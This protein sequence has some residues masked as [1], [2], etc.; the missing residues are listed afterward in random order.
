MTRRYVK[1]SARVEFERSIAEIET[2][3]RQIAPPRKINPDLG[4]Y[5]LSAAILFLSAKL[6][7]YIS[8]LFKGIC[9]EACHHVKSASAVPPSLLGWAFLNDGHADRSKTFVARNDEGD[10]IRTTGTYLASELV[11][12]GNNYLTP[13][14]FRGID[15]KAYPSVKNLKRMFRRLGIEAIFSLLNKRMKCS[16]ENNLESFNAI[17]G[18]LAHSGISGTYSYNDIKEQIL[19]IQQLVSAIDKETFYYLRSCNADIAWK[20]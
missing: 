15:D 10:F 13:G 14:R 9:Q 19:K 7:N 4:N 11:Q 5:I 18:A 20:V 16:A 8:D 1:S 17:R 3:I 6:E 2:V 12:N